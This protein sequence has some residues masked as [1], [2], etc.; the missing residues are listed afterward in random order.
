MGR[1]SLKEEVLELYD[2][3]LHNDVRAAHAVYGAMYLNTI[4]TGRYTFQVDGVGIS[5][6]G[7]RLMRT[8]KKSTVVGQ[9]SHGD[10]NA[11]IG[12]DGHLG[13]NE[14]S[15]GSNPLDPTSIPG[16]VSQDDVTVAKVG[17]RSAT[18]ISSPLGIECGTKC[19][20]S[21]PVGAKVT[22]TANA[23]LGSVF[24]VGLGTVAAC[25]SGRG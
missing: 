13:G 6:R 2:D 11:D 20:A 1:P 21:F 24:S 17:P 7:E 5:S 8:Y 15:S 4:D 19:T 22:L 25:G 3:G 10:K 16:T 12:G 9:D 18:V 14:V 23:N